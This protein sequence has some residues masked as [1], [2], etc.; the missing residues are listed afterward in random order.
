MKWLL[1]K[2][3]AARFER[4]LRNAGQPSADQIQRFTDARAARSRASAD[5]S[6]GCL[7]IAGDVASIEIAGPLTPQPDFWAWLFFGASASYSEIRDALA[8]A[9]AKPEVKRVEFLMDSPG[10][11]VAGLFDTIAAIE[12]FEKPITVRASLAASAAYSLAAVAGK[13]EAMNVAAEFGSVGIVQSFY[14]DEAVV[15]I[16][17]SD[18]PNKRPD[19]TTPEGQAVVR[20]ELDQL[21]EL[22]V[23]AIARGRT[24]A[25]KAVTAEQVNA[26]FGR[27]GMFVAAA[28]RAAGMID[29][30]PPRPARAGKKAENSGEPEGGAPVPAEAAADNGAKPITEKKTMTLELLKAQHP[31]LYAAI[32]SEGEK[33]GSE[34]ERKR[35]NAHIKLGKRSGAMDVAEKAIASGVSPQDDEVWAE[36]QAAAMN[37]RDQ[38]N[39]Q[40]ESDAAGDATKSAK[41]PA[42]GGV[43]DLG[44]RAADALGLPPDPGP[45]TKAA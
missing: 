43:R 14:V 29:K 8:I 13:I 35:V 6:P 19:V 1:Q 12:A 32:L 37:R 17:S 36:Y 33:Q 4:F 16:T 20:E 5:N 11:T 40:E 24:R 27:G 23:D 42:N 45:K 21:H 30:V 18:A 9:G 41:T 25:G 26:E 44:D 15:E 38:A 28:A 7:T 34:K 10:G 39:R 22:M 3:A 31:D 2:D